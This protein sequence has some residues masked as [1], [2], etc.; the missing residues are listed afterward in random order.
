MHKVV[1]TTETVDVQQKVRV[2]D[3]LGLTKPRYISYIRLWEGKA[4]AA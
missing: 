1:S 3:D 2:D 4:A